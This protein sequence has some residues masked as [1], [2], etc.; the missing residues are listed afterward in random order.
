ME[1]IGFSL[2]DEK[3][4]VID[5][6]DFIRELIV[7]FGPWC[8]FG[9]FESDCPQF[10]DAD[11]NYPRLE[12]ALSGFTAGKAPLMS[13][14][15]ARGKAK[16]QELTMKEIQ[17]VIEETSGTEPKTAANGFKINYKAAARN[18]SNGLELKKIE[19]KIRLEL[20]N[21]RTQ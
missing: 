6:G 11:N 2:E 16:P 3:A 18:A 7:K 21:E 19:Q 17:L 20:E 15:E 8:F 10:W 1:A 14:A 12:E 4:S 5:Q 13:E 9:N